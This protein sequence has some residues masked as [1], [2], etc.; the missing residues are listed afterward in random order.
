M[1][2]Y[3]DLSPNGVFFPFFAW[4]F[5]SEYFL[6]NLDLPRPIRFG[7]KT[8]TG[9]KSEV[10]ARNGCTEHVCKTLRFLTH[11][12]GVDI[13]SFVRKTG[14]FGVAAF[15]YFLSV[16]EQL[17]DINRSSCWPDAIR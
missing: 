16:Y 6:G 9:R 17:C 1:S 7:E 13:W 12:N 11:K 14:E 10:G 15:N 4:F 2:P 8:Q 3:K 5:V